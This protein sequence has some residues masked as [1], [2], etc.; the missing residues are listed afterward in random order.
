MEIPVT[1]RIKA[2]VEDAE[3]LFWAHI[4]SVFPEAKSGDFDPLETHRMHNALTEWVQQWVKANTDLLPYTPDT[5]E[6]FEA[7]GQHLIGMG[8]KAHADHTGGGIICVMVEVGQYS[9]WFGTANENWGADVW[10]GEEF[11]DG[12]NIECPYPS[13]T[14]DTFGCAHAISNAVEIFKAQKGITSERPT[15]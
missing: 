1:Q 5:R 13:E 6:W 14:A 7:I 10:Y 4:A 9:L 12:E 3:M 8:Y 11:L 15:A 2:A